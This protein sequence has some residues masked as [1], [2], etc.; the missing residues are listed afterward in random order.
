MICNDCGAGVK[1]GAE[2]CG[3][4]GWRVPK[5]IDHSPVGPL[6]VV[7]NHRRTDNAHCNEIREAYAKRRSSE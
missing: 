2:S 3:H 4:C 5:P 6:R 1:A 7:E